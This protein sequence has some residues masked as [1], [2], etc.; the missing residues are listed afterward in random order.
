LEDGNSIR[1]LLSIVAAA[2]F[3]YPGFSQV[4]YNIN[5]QT[6][7][8]A[9]NQLVTTGAA[10]DHVSSIWFGTPTVVPTFGPL[11]D[12][13]LLF[14][15][16]GQIPMG[17]GYFYTQIQLAFAYVPLPGVDLSFDMVDTGSNHS[18]TVF[19]DTASVRKFQFSNGQISF[20]NPTLSDT[21][22]GNYQMGQAHRFDIHVD[23]LLNQW[24]FTEDTVLLGTGAFNPDGNL[25]SIRFNYSAAGPDI[26]GTAIDNILVVAAQASPSPVGTWEVTISGQNHGIA[27]MTFN[28]D[29]TLSG[30]GMSLESFGMFRLTG[31]WSLDAKGNLLGSYTED[32]GGMTFNG[33]FTGKTAAG[34]R[35]TGKIIASNGKFAMNGIPVLTVLDISGPWIASVTELKTTVPE[36]ITLF[37]SRVLPGVFSLTGS[38][39]GPSGNFR[40]SGKVVVSSKGKAV[41]F[42]ES[43]FDSGGSALSSLTGAFKVNAQTGSFAGVT[44]S[45]V[46]LRAKIGR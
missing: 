12:R 23:Y 27:F 28:D 46:R 7:D 14:N 21:N 26:S 13:P 44:D 25:W 31:T 15:S 11:T 18:F 17:S 43:D 41:V 29:F 1:T 39:S 8:Q 4:A 9:M 38:G 20:M 35:L 32:L 10:P 19:F 40:V 36:A 16:N 30:Y 3:S 34:K 22:V 24:S 2:A 42:T 33:N 45:G 6:A 37:P 5:F